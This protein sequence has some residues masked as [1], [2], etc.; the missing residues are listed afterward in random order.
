MSDERMMASTAGRFC[1]AGA[2]LANISLGLAMLGFVVLL[3]GNVRGLEAWPWGLVAALG[4]AGAWYRFRL[5]FDAGVF[6]DFAALDDGGVAVRMAAFDATL[7]VL[8]GQSRGAS[9]MRS[10]P[11]RVRGARRL[12]ARAASVAAAQSF[13]ALAATLAR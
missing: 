9:A 8:A 10:L 11:D 13:V 12:V 4:L 5:V 7:R 2:T 1:A 3:F 6:A